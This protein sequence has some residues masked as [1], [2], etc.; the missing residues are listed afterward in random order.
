MN[1][2]DNWKSNSYR[3]P[4]ES[5]HFFILLHLSSKPPLPFLL[6]YCCGLV[7]VPL[8]SPTLVTWSSYLNL[9]IGNHTPE[10]LSSPWP[11]ACM[12]RLLPHCCL[13]PGSLLCCG[14][15]WQAHSPQGSSPAPLLGCPS[16]GYSFSCF[17]T[18]SLM[19]CTSAESLLQLHSLK[20]D[21]LFH[22]IPYSG[23]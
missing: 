23:A 19:K 2:L 3:M 18:C 4:L 16:S 9:L 7:T 8:P 13:V 12:A 11:T 5:T 22:F 1:L 17:L 15:L 20:L 21:S 10:P 6:D 14:D